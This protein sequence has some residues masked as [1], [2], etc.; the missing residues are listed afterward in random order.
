[1]GKKSN[2]EQP[3]A[4]CELAEE[5]PAE[6]LAGADCE[7]QAGL[8]EQLRFELQQASEQ[9]KN[10]YDL[11]LRTLAE[12]D[13]LRKR[14]QREKEEL[15]KFANENILRE[16]LSV[17]DNLERAV[18]HAEKAEMGENGAGLLEGVQMTLTEFSRVLGRFGVEAI[19][20]C[21]TS[22]SASGA[23]ALS[24]RL[25]WRVSRI[26]SHSFSARLIFT[27]VQAPRSLYPRSSNKSLPFANP[28]S[29]SARGIHVPRSHTIIGPAPYSPSGMRPSK[30]A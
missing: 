3:E 14:T 11:Y 22:A 2:K 6:E 26:N 24:S 27:S 15:A 16:L 18:E 23:R 29:T 7:E 5:Q 19:D 21:G 17:I 9:S 10:N 25:M 12:M 4:G 30:E 20:A 8:E 28:S 13:N 1:M